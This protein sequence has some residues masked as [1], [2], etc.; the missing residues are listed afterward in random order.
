MEPYWHPV[1]INQVIGRARRICSHSD[2]PQD[3]QDVK[4]FMY[5]L[6]G[7]KRIL[8]GKT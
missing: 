1:R 6:S 8:C 5:L 7:M 4:V 3:L 2:L